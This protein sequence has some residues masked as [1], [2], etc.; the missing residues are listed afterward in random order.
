MV[1]NYSDK[2][3][4]KMKNLSKEDLDNYLNKIDTDTLYRYDLSNKWQD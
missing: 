4:L 1:W 2:S 3:E